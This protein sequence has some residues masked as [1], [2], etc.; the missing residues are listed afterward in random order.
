MLGVIFLGAM[1]LRPIKRQL[2]IY[3]T[4][5]P[6]GKFAN[7]NTMALLCQVRESRPFIARLVHMESTK[8][9]CHF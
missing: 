3:G 7:K 5:R 8:A 6:G 4:A 9:L 2:S 1:A